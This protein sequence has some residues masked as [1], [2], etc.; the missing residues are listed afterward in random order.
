MKADFLQAKQH[1]EQTKGFRLIPLRQFIRD[2]QGRK[3]V[4]F[5]ENWARFKTQPCP[6]REFENAAGLAIITG[7]VSNIIILDFDTQEATDVFCSKLKKPLENVCNYIIKTHRGY[8]L[9]YKY[10]AD[11]KQSTSK[12]IPGLDIL[13]DEKLSFALKEN[14]G[15]EVYVDGEISTMP[16]EVKN[17]IIQKIP[18]STPFDEKDVSY[19]PFNNPL[20]YLC[21]RWLDNTAYAA[22]T[23]KEIS[24]RLLGGVDY[25]DANK[26]GQRHTLAMRVC[27]ICAADPTI[28]ETLY[29]EFCYKFISKV[30]QPEE[31]IYTMIDYAYG[32][33][34]MYDENWEQKHKESKDIFGRLRA[35]GINC[36]FSARDEKYIYHDTTLS[37][38]PL[39]MT[40]Q[41]FLFM[42]RGK[43]D[44]LK[45]TEAELNK[46][47]RLY[48]KKFDPLNEPGVGRDSEGGYFEN[49]YISSMYLRRFEKKRAELLET[50]GEG[51]PKP[52]I[53]HRIDTILKNIIPDEEQR[54]LFLHNV[55]YHMKTKQA[56]QTAF[57]LIGKTQGTGKGLFFDVILNRIYGEHALKW[58]PMSMSANFNGEIENR[59]FIH[60][61][62]VVEKKNIFSVQTFVN[63]FK[64]LIAE[65]SI[66][67]VPKGKE[68]KNVKN[69]SFIVMSSNDEHPFDID[70]GDNRRFN[71]CRTSN[72][73]LSEVLP[74]IDEVNIVPKLEEDLPEFVDYLAWRSLSATEAEYKR[75]IKSDLYEEI[76]E[77]STPVEEKIAD[78][79]VEKNVDVLNALVSEEFANIFERDIVKINFAYMKLSKV[80]ECIGPPL[81]EKVRK[82][83]RR[84]GI[85][86]E[87]RYIPAEKRRGTILLLNPGG[88]FIENIK[89]G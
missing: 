79:I 70:V 72:T 35:L 63:K 57:I 88:V 65:D 76:K 64:N 13:T 42:V 51:I 31:D 48:G 34:F 20:A 29:G 9:F 16:Q 14:P 44:I 41:G 85:I 22:A 66:V 56:A 36:Y 61:N 43:L 62:E 45:I 46:L 33:S 24:N 19:N 74:E 26:E 37:Q 87:A 77:A 53:P 80:K 68:T 5:I 28:S 27:G 23:K 73:P 30:I 69:H 60:C 38:P 39:R 81:F 7:K 40:K 78:A 52:K 21:E 50:C 75:V 2:E 1:Y 84:R 83:L 49:T 10:D 47:P 8:H 25:E 71:F 82:A 6:D 67:I 58:E 32:N 15:Y 17:F 59:L 4:S 89:K 18:S 11:I 54:E 55:S 3:R 86:S 12:V